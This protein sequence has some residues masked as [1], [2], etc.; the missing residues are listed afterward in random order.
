[1]PQMPWIRTQPSFAKSN[2]NVQSVQEITTGKTATP[3]NRYAA[4]TAVKQTPTFTKKTN[5][6]HSVFSKECPRLCRIEAL[7]ISKTDY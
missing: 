5:I 1:M 6:N 4:P 7:I 2:K 3:N